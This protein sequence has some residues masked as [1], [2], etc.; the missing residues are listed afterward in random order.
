MQGLHQCRV[1]CSSAEDVHQMFTPKHFCFLHHFVHAWNR[2]LKPVMQIHINPPSW[3]RPFWQ[4]GLH[5]CEES[6][7]PITWREN[8]CENASTCFLEILRIVQWYRLETIKWGCWTALS[9]QLQMRDNFSTACTIAYYC[10]LRYSQCLL[11]AC[12][13][14]AREWDS[15]TADRVKS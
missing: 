1:V 3:V 7:Q 14:S 9:S 4:T 2:C 13:F 11:H 10:I 5:V 12:L 15:D 8:V 6:G